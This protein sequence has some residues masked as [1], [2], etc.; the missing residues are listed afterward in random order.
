MKCIL[1]FVMIMCHIAWP[2][3][4]SGTV[5][6]YDFAQDEITFSADSRSVELGGGSQVDT[7]CKISA[8]GDRFVFMATGFTTDI[9]RVHGV[10]WSAHVQAR[11]AWVRAA[12]FNNDVSSLVARVSTEWAAAVE[13]HFANPDLIKALRARLA[14]A[15]EPIIVGGLFAA[16]DVSGRLTLT[17]VEVLVDLPFFDSTG[18]VRLRHEIQNGHPNS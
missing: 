8:F 18:Q 4:R 10:V 6:Y 15:E 17:S 9:N 13:S 11:A 7:H 2:Q 14:Q 16:T 1:S 12:A 3:I 5:V